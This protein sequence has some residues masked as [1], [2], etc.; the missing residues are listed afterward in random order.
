MSTTPDDVA[1]VPI[2]PWT[3]SGTYEIVPN[4]AMPM[5]PMQRMLDATIGFRI[6]SNGRIGSSTRRSQKPN[7][8]SRTPDTASATMTW[9][10]P[11]RVLAPAPDEPEQQRGRAGASSAE[12]EPVDRVRQRARGAAASSAR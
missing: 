12:S 7:T 3:N 11:P 10:G 9:L 2:T 4:I 8:A 6:T 5:S 1:D